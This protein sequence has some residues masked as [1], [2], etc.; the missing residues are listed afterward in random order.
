M[1][2]PQDKTYLFEQMPVSRAVL[3]Q[4]LPSIASQMVLLALSLIHI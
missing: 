1:Q 2:G 4:I 3:R